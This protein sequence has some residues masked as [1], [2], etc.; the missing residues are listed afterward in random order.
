[1]AQAVM[2]I[3][4]WKSQRRGARH[5][6]CLALFR[7]RNLG[8]YYPF[9]DSDGGGCSGTP[10]TWAGAGGTSFASPIMAGIQ[11]LVN[12]K[13]GGR[14]GNPNPV[15][16]SLAKT[17][18]GASGDTSCNSSLGNTVGSSCIFYDVTLGDMDVDCLGANNCYLDAAT[19]V[20]S[21]LRTAPMIPHS[22]RKPAGTSQRESGR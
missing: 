21:P 2:A 4:G 13:A 6:R 18:Y 9:C 11:A 7:Q 17:E 5:A 22:A 10:E 15:Y 8:H 12:Q 20:C 3:G 19:N 1:M 16:Y 14:Q